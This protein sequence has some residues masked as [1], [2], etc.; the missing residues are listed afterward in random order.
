MDAVQF[1]KIVIFPYLSPNDSEAM[2]C[3][4]VSFLREI[5]PDTRP[6]ATICKPLRA[7]TKWWRPKLEWSEVVH[8]VFEKDICSVLCMYMKCIY[9]YIYIYIYVLKK[10]RPVFGDQSW[11][12]ETFGHHSRK[13]S[14]LVPIMA[15]SSLMSIAFVSC[16][17]CAQKNA[18]RFGR[19]WTE[20]PPP[21]FWWSNPFPL[22]FH[23]QMVNYASLMASK[24]TQFWNP[25]FRCAMLLLGRSSTHFGLADL[26]NSLVNLDFQ[27]PKNHSTVFTQKKESQAS[28]FSKKNTWYQY[29][30][31]IFWHA[32]YVKKSKSTSL[33][34]P[35]H[36]PIL[37]GT[38]ERL[39]DPFLT[40]N[41]GLDLCRRGLVCNHVPT[42]SNY[43]TRK[44]ENIR[45]HHVLN[46][47]TEMSSVPRDR[48]S[49]TGL[50]KHWVFEA[51]KRPRLWR[52][53]PGW[54]SCWGSRFGEPRSLKVTF[55][56]LGEDVCCTSPRFTAEARWGSRQMDPRGANSCARRWLKLSFSR[57]IDV[58]EYRM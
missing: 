32:F 13:D 11:K 4:S 46:P 49:R 33:W 3:R 21:V 53:D 58:G 35:F 24:S 15:W 12:K 16:W 52:A 44:K 42:I 31:I 38:I 23:N 9:M 14:S 2:R 43:C 50:K 26:Q 29:V 36:G 45:E 48:D 56:I 1:H 57:S 27:V 10:K 40:W 25:L 51:T 47:G 6:T 41:E 20:T 37:P 28:N 39:L 55:R 22:R 8:P 30:K 7:Q 18:D 17:S 34:H 54:P 19:F 5:S